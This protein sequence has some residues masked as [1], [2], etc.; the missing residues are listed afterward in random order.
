MQVTPLLAVVLI[1]AGCSFG[2]TKT[3]TNTV[4]KTVTT[5]ASG[6]DQSGVPLLQTYFGVPV[7]T[8]SATLPKVCDGCQSRK[9]YALV[10]KP[11]FF[12]S[13]AT[14]TAAAAD[15]ACGLSCPPVPDDYLVIPAGTKNLTF[16][17]PATAKGTVITFKS[18]ND[19]PATVTAAQ[20]V[21]LVGGATT[22]KL[23]EPLSDGVWFTVAYDTVRSFAQQYRP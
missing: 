19:H 7:S 22:P 13:G 6:V 23:F 18:G 5:Q 11:E 8:T 14:A 1:V 15:G 21:A 12:L 3:T 2:G 16:A 9:G 4:T 10:I 17:L 20:F